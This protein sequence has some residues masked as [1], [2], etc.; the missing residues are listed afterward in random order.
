MMRGLGYLVAAALLLAVPAGAVEP[1]RVRI[2]DALRT[3]EVGSA[4]LVRLEDAA[5]RRALF[6][7]PGGRVIRLTPS[8]GGIDVSWGATPGEQRRVAMGGVRL[9]ISRG[10]LRVGTRE[11]GGALEAW[12]GADGLTLVNELGLEEYVAGT[13]RAETSEKWPPDALRA[14]AVVA[15]TFAVFHQQKNA[16][17]P[18]HLVA[19]SQ[20]QNYGGRVPEGMPSA[21]ATRATAGQVLTWQGAVFP[22][23]YHSD[24]G[25][26]TEPPQTIF[27][28]E[29]IP[30]LPGVR[31]EFS[32][33][34]PNYSWVL[35]LP[36]TVV[37][38]RLRQGGLDVGAVTGLAV[39][40][41]SASFR[42]VRLA[43]EHTRGTT[44]VKGTD[45]RRLLGYDVV[46]STLFVP[47]VEDGAVR[48]E[49]RGWGHGA[50]LSQY[51]AKGMADR[52]YGYRDILAHYYPGTSLAILK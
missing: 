28:G 31:D 21:E 16:T 18:Y 9:V 33:D 23:F 13:V 29:G 49:G 24:S 42:V 25:G 5:A 4:E 27:S 20:H 12:R 44:V 47:V 1:V 34:S 7:I 19:G 48:F 11:Y 43:V 15:R 41:R 8:G 3:V 39:L 51:G 10:V 37:A 32:V 30:P 26:Y 38:E 36:L 35:S 14:M 6:G 46:K 40:E 2:E 22:T 52:G 17:R 45:F 50:G